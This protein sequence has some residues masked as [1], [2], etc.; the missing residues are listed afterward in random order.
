MDTNKI[1]DEPLPQ[2]WLYFSIKVSG[3]ANVAWKLKTTVGSDSKYET[4][5]VKDV[6]SSAW[7]EFKEG[8]KCC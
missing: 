1:N 7:L 8:C 4:I 6:D 2:Y 5:F 3:A